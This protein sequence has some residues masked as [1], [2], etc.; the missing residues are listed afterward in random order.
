M[1]GYKKPKTYARVDPGFLDRGFKFTKGVRFACF[2]TSFIYFAWF[3]QA[4]LEPQRQ[5]FTQWASFLFHEER[6]GYKTVYAQL[7]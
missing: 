3:D 5:I 1:A 2:T 4:G 7:D 6:P